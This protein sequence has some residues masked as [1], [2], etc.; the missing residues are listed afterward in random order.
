MGLVPL[1]ASGNLEQLNDLIG[2][3]THDLPGFSLVPQPN[4]LP[5]AS[6]YIL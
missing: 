2:F 5:G 6:L 4:T 3:R 1:K